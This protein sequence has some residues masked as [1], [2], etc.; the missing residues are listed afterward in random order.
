MI[1]NDLSADLAPRSDDELLAV[2]CLASTRYLKTLCSQNGWGYV[3]HSNISP[4]HDL[5]R[6]G[7]HLNIIKYL[8]GD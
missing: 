5:N 8:R 7:L 1:S 3:D 2:K 6:S 4:E